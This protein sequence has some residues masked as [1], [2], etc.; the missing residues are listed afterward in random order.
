EAKL[1]LDPKYAD[2]TG[3][4]DD[5]LPGVR[6]A[7]PRLSTAQKR[8][9]AKNKERVQGDD[10]NVLRYEHFSIVMNGKRRLAFF[11][12][13]NIDGAHSKDFDR[14]TGAITVPESL[15]VDDPDEGPEATELWLADRR[16]A[17]TEQTPPDLFSA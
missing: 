7:L 12:A 2:R 8:D 9:A 17:E 1:I 13:T 5:F 6:I 15:G 4:K 11:T 3:Y 16:L 14:Q 10:P